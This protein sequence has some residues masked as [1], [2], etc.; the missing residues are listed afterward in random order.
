MENEATNYTRGE[1]KDEKHAGRTMNVLGTGG[2]LRVAASEPDLR[3]SDMVCPCPSSRG[4]CFG[5][6]G[7]PGSRADEEREAVRKWPRGE[8]A[9]IGLGTGA[10]PP[11]CCSKALRRS[12]T[13]DIWISI[14]FVFFYHLHHRTSTGFLRF[15]HSS[16]WA[17][18]R[19]DDSLVQANGNLLSAIGAFDGWQSV[20]CF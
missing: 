2:T 8:I 4:R 12:P 6:G 1:K 14:I 18:V 16:L 17:I 3:P 11:P 13:D 5:T 20:L 7:F 15:L 10:P 9:A 19:L